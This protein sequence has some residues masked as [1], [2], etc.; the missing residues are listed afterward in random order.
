MLILYLS[1]SGDGRVEVLQF[2]RQRSRKKRQARQPRDCLPVEA[3]EDKIESLFSELR[4]GFMVS[5]LS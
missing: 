3:V 5:S 1:I 4:D 2:L